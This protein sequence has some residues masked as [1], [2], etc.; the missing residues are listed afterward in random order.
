M[1][2]IND[3]Y[4]MKQNNQPIRMITCYDYW[5]AKIIAD[6]NIDCVLV[7]DSAAMV[8]HGAD[9]TTY[10]DIEMIVVHI[11]AVKNGIPHKFIIGDLPFLSYRKSLNKAMIA[12]EK[13]IKA[14]ANAVKLE[15]I[16]GNEKIVKHIIESGIPVMGHLGFTPQSVNIFGNKIVQGKNTE[17]AEKLMK[18]TKMVEELG[19]FA[20]VLE[21]IPSN[22]AK[23]ITDS[24]S[25]PTIGIGA[26]PHTSGQVLVLQDMLGANPNFNPKFLK[27]Y[28]D[29]Y[30]IIKDSINAYCHEVDT[31][32]FPSKEHC[33]AEGKNADN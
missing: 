21:C 2:D 14:G 5:S 8:M 25:I 13:I 11:K 19:C 12:V 24:L 33:Y 17:Q 22:L 10:A 27:K 23:K 15:G 4:K 9:S 1:M 20:L 26:G 28:A 7:G 16:E 18:D 31:H 29:I 6:T 32:V 30:S 3:F